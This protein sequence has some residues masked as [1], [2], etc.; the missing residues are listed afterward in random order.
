[1]D[2]T[3]TESI[4]HLLKLIYALSYNSLEIRNP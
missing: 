4:D 3:E 2:A 1:M